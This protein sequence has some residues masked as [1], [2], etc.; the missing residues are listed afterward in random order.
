MR[1]SASSTKGEPSLGR[2]SISLRRPAEGEPHPAAL[3][4]AAVG[5]A[6]V[7]LVAVPLQDALE[8]LQHLFGMDAGTTGGVGE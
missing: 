5:E 7:A 1:R 2:A 6:V 3:G 4:P 8:A